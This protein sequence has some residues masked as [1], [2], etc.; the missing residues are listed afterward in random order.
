MNAEGERIVSD[1]AEFYVEQLVWEDLELSEVSMGVHETTSI[2]TIVLEDIKIERDQLLIFRIE[3][4]R[5]PEG[6]M[7]VAEPFYLKID[8]V[9]EDREFIIVETRIGRMENGEF[10]ENSREGISVSIEE[11]LELIPCGSE[12]LILCSFCWE[13][14]CWCSMAW[15]MCFNCGFD[16]SEC[17][18]NYYVCECGEVVQFVQVDV[19]NRAIEELLF[20][21]AL[22]TFITGV[23]TNGTVK[24]LDR[25]PIVS[26]P[27]TFAGELIYTFPVDKSVNPVQMTNGSVMIQT[28]RIFN[29]GT[30]AGYVNE[31]SNDIPAGLEFLPMH[32]TNV[33]YEWVM[34]DVSGQVTTDASEAVE[35][36]TRYLENNSIDAFDPDLGVIVGNPD[37]R[38]IQVAFRVTYEGGTGRIIV[39]R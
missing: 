1:S 29:E 37:Y 4:I 9:L 2:G 11:R 23:E 15:Y 34:Y 32:N 13:N 17:I 16:D 10:I 12:Q 8:T 36:R 5:A 14:P 18:C 27:S 39:S 28:I 21:L 22:R 19:E 25:A 26:M 33:R 38:D 31:I 35:I 30:I 6:Y 24:E 20:N 3:E 7:R